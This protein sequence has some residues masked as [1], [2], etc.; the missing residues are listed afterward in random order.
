LATSGVSTFD[1]E[2]DD[3]LQDAVAMVGGGPILADELQ[4]GQRGIN[5]LMASI[6]NKNI[7]YTRLKRPSF[8]LRC[9]FRP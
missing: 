7:L 1:P 5:Y 3:I 9:R 4:A 8:P 6:Q 2:F